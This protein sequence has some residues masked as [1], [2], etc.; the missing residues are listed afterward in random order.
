M[1]K[2]LRGPPALSTTLIK[3]LLTYFK[4]EHLPL[5]NIYAEY[6]YFI[7]IQTPLNITEQLCLEHLLQSK[8]S[9]FKE[10]LPTG[11]LLLVT[12][13]LGTISSWSSKATDLVRS[14]SLTKILRI[15]RGKAFY[16]KSR[17][18]NQTEWNYLVSK[19]YDRMIE[20]S[21]TNFQNIKQL[22]IQNKPAPMQ[23]IQI[24]EKGRTA[25]DQANISLNLLLSEEEI[26][27]L[28]TAFTNL[29]RN[30][31]DI[32]LYMFAQANSEHCRHKIFNAHWCIDGKIQSK[33]L[34]DMI[35]NTVKKNPNYIL[36]AYNDNSAV[37]EGAP[38]NL[39]YADQKGFY[40]F[41]KNNVHI[42]MKV[43]THNHPTAISPRPGAAT[44]SGGEIR[45]EGATG[46]GAQPKAALSGFSVSNLRIPGFEQPWEQDFGKP[47]HISSALEIMI[48]APLG[49]ADFN[50]EFGRPVLNG[51]FRTYEEMVNS[52]NGS[53][54]RG[55]HKPIMLAG[56][57]GHILEE[58]IQ[59]SRIHD[60][61]K[62]IVLGGPAMNIGL[63]G[64]AASSSSSNRSNV[65]YDFASVQ[66]DNPEMERRCQEVI[67][68]CWQLGSN[69]PIIF[70]HDVGAGGLSNALPEMI[71]HG[72]CGGRFYLRNIL[73]HE[74]GM[75][76]LQI[77]CN[78][79]QERY[80]MAVSPKNLKLF[81][82]ICQR[83]R[84]P[85]VIIG[86]AIKEKKLSLIDNYFNNTPVDIPLS[87]LLG[88][89]P[90]MTRNVTSYKTIGSPLQY[91]HISL[92]D[93]VY[94]IL[95][96]PA[97]AEKTFLITIG[98]RSIGGMVARDQMIGPWQVPVANCAV[99]NASLYH[100]SYHGE[101]MAIGERA[102]VS[103]LNFSASSRLA[104]GEALTNIVTA[105][106]GSITRIKLSANWMVAAGHPGED[107][108]L[109]AAVKTVC[110]ELCPELGIA[111]PVGKDSMS[112]K[113][114][115]NQDD[116]KREVI[117]PLSPIM[118]AFSYVE[119]VRKTVTPQL[120][121][122]DNAIIFI[123]LGN[124]VNA[125]G[126]TAFAQVYRQLG[127]ITADVRNVQQLVNFWK[128]IQKLVTFKKLLAYHD[129]SDGGLLVTLAEMAFAGHCSVLIDIKDLSNDIFAALFTE[130]LG[131]VI[132]VSNNDLSEV[133][134]IL[135]DYNL[136]HCSYL[137]GQAVKG[138]Q[139]IIS[140]GQSIIYKERRTTLR[141]WW[142]ETTWKIQRLRDNPDCADQEHQAKLDNHDPGLNVVLTFDPQENITSTLIATRKRPK[143]AILREQGI[144]SHIEMAAAFHYA[145]FEAIDIHMSDLIE[146]RST[147]NDIKILVACGGFSYGDVLGAG[148]GW[149][150]SILYNNRMRDL[151]EDFFHQSETLVLGVCNGCQMLSNLRELIPGS[152]EWPY[153][154]RNKS[155]RFEGRLSLVEVLKSKSLLF[156]GMTGSKIPIVVAH[157]EGYA[158]ARNKTNLTQLEEKDLIT[159]RFVNNFGY[160]TQ[161]Y[162][163]NPNGSPNGIAAITNENGRVTIMMPHPERIYRTIN[164][165]WH[166]DTWGEDSPW[167]RLFRNARKQ[168][169]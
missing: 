1:I 31:T 38:S 74:S 115:W 130:E 119:D 121:T 136:N 11:K 86:E 15:E 33:S 137:I 51:Y 99:T 84:T 54:L 113:T 120:Q 147:L 94:R 98:D 46:R 18:L 70:I 4:E 139:F 7:Q 156:D 49:A 157:A 12:P 73:N 50:N 85:Y 107:A 109:Y 29:R 104:I 19:L 59:K 168:I 128:A 58:H 145:G 25:L 2:I 151:F 131:A 45:D 67:N 140:R 72:P 134:Q 80:V 52:H 32:E 169:G 79:S 163:A 34:F 5:Q 22:F 23:Y 118:T 76:P 135:K 65:D 103:L 36:S 97:V 14:C 105:Q 160:P 88:T 68:R 48:E 56:G 16:I 39:F 75:S 124:G 61:D 26:Q 66:R 165:S 154:I 108:G 129:R 123:D 64:G 30:P 141:A 164:H 127:E 62:F 155:D 87:L 83:E 114:K 101:A 150:K 3:K 111:I 6:I 142:A 159:L 122:N 21:F 96:L 92:S 133:R 20:A 112:M 47:N 42:L 161:K 71:H 126:A 53:E 69:N 27:Y 138:N 13:R 100:N 153:F 41:N 166:P 93:A 82:T 28:M 24:L 77:W 132:Q 35:Q 81:D 44:G 37:M 149:A 162:P 60:G 158:K 167:M 63:G 144:N 10:N 143:A 106:I 9:L 116:E 95:H 146:G 55:Y 117:A 91:E 57:L 43:E 78:E 89:F 110:E 148:S 8:P 40:K 17:K 90:K 152:K 125:L 102:P